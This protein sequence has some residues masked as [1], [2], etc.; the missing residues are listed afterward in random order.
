[1]AEGAQEGVCQPLLGESSGRRGTVLVLLVYC[2]LGAL[3]MA[4]YVWGFAT[5]VHRYHTAMG[6]WGR[7]AQPSLNWLRYTYYASMGLAA[8]GY[9]P[10]LAHMLVVAGTLPKHVVDRICG[11][12]AIFFFTELFWLPMCVAYLDKPNA[13]LFLFIRLQLACSGLSA[14]AWAYSVLTI[15]SSSVEVSGRPLQ[16]AAFAGTSYFAFHCAVLD[17]I[18][19]PPMFHA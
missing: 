3:L 15:P 17:G 4:D 6:L 18:L 2:G 7:M 19:W 11:F 10:A 9:F 5:L 8:V 1:M 12:F 13:T 14:I 16:L